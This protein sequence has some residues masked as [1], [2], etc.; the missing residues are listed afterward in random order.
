MGICQKTKYLPRADT[1]IVSQVLTN[2]R[3]HIN[4]DQNLM[5]LEP[6]IP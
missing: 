5:D 6:D 3:Y 1:M 2:L 4:S